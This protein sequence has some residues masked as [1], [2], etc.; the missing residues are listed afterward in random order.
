MTKKRKR[1]NGASNAAQPVPEPKRESRTQGPRSRL[2]GWRT[3][4]TRAALA[5]FG[6]LLVLGAF[7]LTLRVVGFGWNTHFF[8]RSAGTGDYRSNPKFG[9]RFFGRDLSQPPLPLIL[10][11]KKPDNTY[12]I[13]VFGSSAALGTP[14]PAFSFSRILEAMLNDRYPALRFDVVNTGMVAINS[15]VIL[16]IVRDCRGLGG[17]LFVVYMGNNEVV[18]PF[19]PGSVIRGYAPSVGAIRAS[20]FLQST[21]LGQWLRGMLEALRGSRSKTLREWGGMEMFLENRVAADDPQLDRT[22]AN[23]EA[24]LREIIREAQREKAGVIVSTVLTNVKDLPPFASVHRSG[25]SESDKTQWE[26]A[27]TEG[28]ALETAGKPR[29]AVGTYEIAAAIDDRYALLQFRMGRCF[30]AMGEYDEARRRLELARD[31]DALRFRADTRINR[32]I[33]ETAGGRGSEGVYLVDAERSVRGNDP[34]H[35]AG[36]ELLY[37]HVHLTF[38][39]NYAIA[40][41]L[42]EEVS[43]RLPEQTRESVNVNLDAPS[44]ERCAE[45]TLFSP[46]L[47]H[48]GYCNMSAL[49]SKPPF[50]REWNAGFLAKR[51]RGAAL[52]A[53]ILEETAE[54]YR[55]AL[56]K[57]PDDLSAREILVDFLLALGRNREAVEHCQRLLD[58]YPD[59]PQARVILSRALIEEG[60]DP[61]AMAQLRTVLEEMPYN[62]DARILMG[63]THIR[64]NEPSQAAE[65]FNAAVALRPGDGMAQAGLGQAL[66]LLKEPGK[67]EKHCALAV[68]TEP[69][70]AE[71]RFL[72]GTAL[73]DQGKLAQA[74]AAFTRATEL[75]PRNPAYHYNLAMNAYRLGQTDTA[76]SHYETGLALDPRLAGEFPVLAAAFGKR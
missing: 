60:R 46:L 53:G 43:R 21:R 56:E 9:W 16:P 17:D 57:R 52:P 41:A 26:K 64:R 76:R 15:H 18:G 13:F 20:L 55:R 25:L 23:F 50:D 11:A 12:R 5:V 8:V 49:T 70:R 51:D 68:E 42:F 44:L 34:R 54:L 69:A 4:P 66:V 39:G 29:E 7:E 1:E 27:F 35:I 36:E 31:L 47:R 22:V 58:R 40:A 74:L 59:W 65:E 3:W 45:L 67:A 48:R 19:G 33:R 14:D 32:A 37:E 30:L 73:R 10:P 71:Y 24:N 72:L 75:D 6:P 62:G 38:E 2:T 28:L 63:V 61:E